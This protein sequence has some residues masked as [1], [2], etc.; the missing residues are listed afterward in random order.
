MRLIYWIYNSDILEKTLSLID[1]EICLFSMLSAWCR[2]GSR[3]DSTSKTQT[4]ECEQKINFI[5]DGRIKMEIRWA[6]KKQ[7]SS[8]VFFCTTEKMKETH[9]FDLYILCNT[10]TRCPF[11]IRRI[12]NMSRTNEL[13]HDNDRA[14]MTTHWRDDNYSV[15]RDHRSHVKNLW[16]YFNWIFDHLIYFLCW[17][18]LEFHLTSRRDS[19]SQGSE[20]TWVKNKKSHLSMFAVQ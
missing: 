1:V 2:V 20:A 19:E 12:F 4:L 7:C 11:D 16:E 3:I 17:F 6:K 10:F 8:F 14:P 9:S 13:K 15:V 18:T 5:I